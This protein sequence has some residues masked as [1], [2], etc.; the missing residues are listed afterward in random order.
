MNTKNK[1]KAP[2]YSRALRLRNGMIAIFCVFLLLIGRLF[3]L[4]FI[5]GP[6]LKEQMYSQLITSR[7]ISP[8]RGTIYDTNGKELAISA[9]VDTV[10][11]NP[12]L[13]K[14]SEENKE[15][16][17]IK[18][19][20]LKEK[21]AK[22]FSEIFEL[23][24]EKTLAKVNSTSWLETIV[25]KVQK[26]KIDKLK[27]WMEEEKIYSGINIDE[28]TKR[29]YPYNN[30]ASNLI[31]FCGDENRGLE[32]LENEFDSLL[33]GTFLTRTRPYLLQKMVII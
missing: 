22:A 16:E 1:S 33:T 18:T 30:L 7:A 13:I 20:A 29:Y 32:G 6:W 19:K 25:S 21:V 12:D 24:Y 9:A 3:W 8:K 5:K 26:D 10:T 15:L 2:K 31:G 23:D 14:V 17:E 28:D 27:K 11:I 4:Q